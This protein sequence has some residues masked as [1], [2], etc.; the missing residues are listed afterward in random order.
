M[1]YFP[2]AGLSSRFTA[3]GYSKPKYYL[4]VGKWNLFQLS[5]LGFKKYFQTDKFCFIHLNEFVS[6]DIIQGWASEA[7]LPKDNFIV[8]S[9]DDRT[10]GQADSVR[11]G[12]T[13]S[14][15]FLNEEVIIFNV[16][17]IYDEFSKPEDKVDNYLDVTQMAGD[18]WSFVDPDPRFPGLASRV[19]EKRRISDLC[20]VGLYQFSTGEEFL[21]AYALTY[22]ASEL[23]TEAY[24]APMYQTLINNRTIVRYREYAQSKFTFLGT[25]TEY[26]EHL[27]KVTLCRDN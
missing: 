17:T 5:L 3:E 9:L 11:Q 18:H 4:E 21:E 2:M 23:D 14:V 20:S 22:G 19:V 6:A 16:D 13:R 10:V 15:D 27:R 7:G 12:I 1:F 26:K 24:V 25:P 8:I